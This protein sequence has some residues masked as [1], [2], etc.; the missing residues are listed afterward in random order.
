MG[1][2]KKRKQ[3]RDEKDR[4]LMLSLF[5]AQTEGT[6]KTVVQGVLDAINI[7]DK[8]R[9]EYEKNLATNLMHIIEDPILSDKIVLVVAGVIDEQS[10][11]YGYRI[12]K[13]KREELAQDILVALSAIKN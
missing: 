8:D 1:Y 5:A 2:F 7:F 10:N 12:A 9:F 11:V 13:Q 3:R 6:H 4:D